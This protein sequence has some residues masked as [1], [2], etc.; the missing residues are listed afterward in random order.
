MSA[1]TQGNGGWNQERINLLKNTVCPKGISNDEFA[2]FLEQCKR[3]G[4][5]PLL[6][7]AFCV[8]R[9]Q[10]IGD[11]DRPNWVTKHEFQPSEAGML[12]RAER[13]PDYEGIQAAEVYGKDPIS[14]DYGSGLVEHKVNPAQ[15][16]GGLVGAWARVQRRGKLAVVVWVDL[17]AVEQKTP[18]WTKM[19]A[20]MVRKCA[21]VAALRTAYP[22]AFGGLYVR[23]EMPAEEFDDAP[24]N[25]SPVGQTR[26]VLERAALPAKSASTE[27][28]EVV[29]GMLRRAEPEAAPVAAQRETAQAQ[30]ATTPAVSA[31]PTSPV[32]I[33]TFGP[34]K[35]ARVVEIS[36]EQLSETLDLGNEKLMEQPKARWANA[37]RACMVELEAEVG[38]RID[39]SKAPQTNGS[40]EPGED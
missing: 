19:P 20:T 40:R 39:A 8:A 22:E 14:I 10:N 9:R 29:S 35:G 13:F 38:R 17:P 36:D 12:A 18:L 30:A 28:N 37:M 33:V 26:P 31:T 4:L 1:E 3:S 24:A 16:S 21:R 25:A 23:E 2:L 7:E 15:R 34:H 32:G 27:A 6:K 11:R 5:D